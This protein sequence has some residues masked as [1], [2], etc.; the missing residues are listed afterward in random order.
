MTFPNGYPT[1]TSLPPAPEPS[2]HDSAVTREPAQT[3]PALSAFDSGAHQKL[4][5]TLDE[6]EQDQQ[7]FQQQQQAAPQVEV[8]EPTGDSSNIEEERK[9]VSEGGLEQQPGQEGQSASQPIADVDAS[10]PN[11]TPAPVADE[12]TAITSTSGQTDPKA[13]FENGK[14]PNG[15]R[16][17]RGMG[18]P[19]QNRQHQHRPPQHGQGATAD[20][21]TSVDADGFEQ[22]GKRQGP[23]MRG[24]MGRGRGFGGER[25][26]GV[27]GRGRGQGQG[28]GE[29]WSPYCSLHIAEAAV[30][31]QGTLT[32]GRSRRTPKKRRP[33]TQWR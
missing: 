30:M 1:P 15:P 28:Q 23:P 8:V 6:D 9:L 7:H 29:R 4:D 2:Q 24:G 22:V 16:R 19:P 17:G 26:R 5:W 25:G 21:V 32:D 20:A 27:G 18:R 13:G 33:W 31:S 12:A 11:E 10:T 3:V 14:V